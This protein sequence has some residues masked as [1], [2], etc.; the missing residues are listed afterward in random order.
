MSGFDQHDLFGNLHA[1]VEAQ[2]PKTPDELVEGLT[3]P[4]REAVEHRD[5]PLLIVA[6][7]GSGKTRV[8]TR[9][10]A[11][12][13]ATGDAQ[14]H[15]ILAITFTNKAANEMVER[16]VQLVGDRAKRMWV[17]TF[18]KAF[19]RIL[20]TESERLGYRSRLTLYD[21]SDSRRLIQEI[22]KER[23]IDPKKVTPK[24]VAGKISLAKANFADP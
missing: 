1:Q 7:A 9:R 22:M 2:R 16:L 6:G 18:H 12:L 15:E 10:I 23:D 3:S 5:G 13:L 14:P 11:H 17:M 20:Q 19:Y 21:D 4:Q 8:L 24:G